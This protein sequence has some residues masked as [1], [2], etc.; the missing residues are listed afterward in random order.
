MK[1]RK[2]LI[3]A[4]IKPYKH[5]LTVQDI[6]ATI[7]LI[8]ERLKRGYQYTH[9]CHSVPADK[10]VGFREMMKDLSISVM[11]QKRRDWIVDYDESEGAGDKLRIA[12]LQV[13]KDM[14]RNRKGFIGKRIEYTLQSELG[15][16]RGIIKAKTPGSKLYQV[17]WDNKAINPFI[18]GDSLMTVKKIKVNYKFI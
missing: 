15:P 10:W 18:F 13:W 7:A 9:L 5:V 3:R 1:F 8:K 12:F 17:V 14:I 16:Y 11:E 4:A 2:D 6:D